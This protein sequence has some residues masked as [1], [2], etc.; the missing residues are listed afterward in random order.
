MPT[1]TT[2]LSSRVEESLAACPQFRILVIGVRKPSL[3][4]SAFNMSLKNMDS[5]HN[6]AGTASISF[7][8]NSDENPRFILHD[9]QGFEPGSTG[10]WN[11]LER[12]LRE[13]S[14]TVELKD[15]VHAI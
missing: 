10:N 1:I 5:P 7:A 12:F 13:R 14:A 6:R 4:S 9:S 3:V 8:Y 15:P 2:N 11:I